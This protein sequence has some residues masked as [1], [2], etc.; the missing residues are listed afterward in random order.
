MTSIFV[1]L[2]HYIMFALLCVIEFECKVVKGWQ[3]MQFHVCWFFGNI[4]NYILNTKPNKEKKRI[5]PLIIRNNFLLA[6]FQFVLTNMEQWSQNL[7]TKNKGGQ[8][9]LQMI[10]NSRINQNGKVK[11]AWNKFKI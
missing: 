10:L 9:K 7:E 11:N 1:P 6:K 4:G 5:F 8:F 3:Q 2:D